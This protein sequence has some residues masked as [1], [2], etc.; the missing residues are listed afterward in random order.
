MSPKSPELELD[1]LL[2]AYA[3]NK[4]SVDP[5][6][7]RKEAWAPGSGPVLFGSGALGHVVLHGLRRSGVEPLGFVDNNAFRWGTTVDGL[8]VMSLAKAIERFGRAV[9]IVVTIYTGAEVEA[10]LCDLNLHVI[11]FPQLA[12]A[13]PET[14]LPWGALDLPSRMAAQAGPIREAF[15]LWADDL[16]REEYVA[17]VRFRC[18]FAGPLPPHLPAEAT[19]FPGEL[20]SL[21]PDEVFVDCG[22]FD[23]DSINAFLK[24]SGGWLEGVVGIEA[25]PQNAEKLRQS[26]ARLPTVV[27]AKI[28]VVQAAVG[29]RD[30]TIQFHATG[31]AASNSLD[32]QGA[33]EVPCRRLDEILR[34]RNASYLKMDIEG[35]EPQALAGAREIIQRDAP[36][37]AICLYH[38]QTDLWEIPLQVREMTDRYHFFL[39]RYSDDCWEQVLYAIPH[40]RVRN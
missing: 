5:S 32:G 22:A 17:Q 8:P 15:S 26:V 14:L 25:D 16:S 6:S 10:R 27:G 9:P 33:I 29:A 35:A 34:H 37:L 21:K 1:Q 3:E 4:P 23:G 11:R 31:T 39:R 20:V 38:R 30:G 2:A 24:R 40:E 19:Y 12:L 18:T 28:E 36:V 7:V 13:F